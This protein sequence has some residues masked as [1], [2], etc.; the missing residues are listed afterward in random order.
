[1]PIALRFGDVELLAFA[2]SGVASYV[3]IPAYRAC[4]D[5]GHCPYEAASLDHVFL[6]H[7]HQDHALGVFR[8]HALR[9][10]NGSPLAKVYAPAESLD[11]L[12]DAFVAIRAL[13]GRGSDEPL[14]VLHGVRAGDEI[15]LSRERRV[16]V[17][18]A[19][20]R[21]ASRAY[22]VIESRREPLPGWRDATAEER[23]AARMRGEKVSE[24]QDVAAF[25]YIGDST[26]ATLE[27]HPEVGASEILFV[28][29]TH[30][31]PTASELSAKWG[32]THLDDLIDLMRRAPDTFA[33]RYIVLKHFSTRYSREQIRKALEEIPDGIRG[34]VVALV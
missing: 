2:I 5:L 28:E 33:S 1:V 16:R 10:M 11:A 22:T 29:A 32:H 27:R 19:E 3:M 34:R 14:P 15:E 12:R 8:H 30:V 13:E 17:F 4:F 20:H 23:R 21:I 25:T 9:R 6:T 26:I 18:D 31:A 7:V 24:P